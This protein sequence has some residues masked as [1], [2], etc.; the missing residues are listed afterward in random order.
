MQ[1]GDI[2]L[3]SGN[4]TLSRRIAKT[5][6][7]FAKSQNRPELISTGATEI[8]HVAGVIFGNV[9]FEAT[10]LNEWC[11]KKGVQVNYFDEWRK[12]YNGKIYLRE[13]TGKIN[14]Y[15]VTKCACMYIGTPYE[16]GIPGA[17]ELAL[18]G[19]EWQW[20]RK[21]F[22]MPNGLTETTSLHCS[23]V[24]AKVLIMSGYLAYV[25]A[26]KMPPMEWWGNGKFDAALSR[27]GYR[28]PVRIK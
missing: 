5:Q 7:F 22:N 12:N 27:T 13:N 11:G 10:T 17:L 4:G 8:T 16:S 2:L 15:V 1:T 19:I 23:E 25:Q 21:T 24:I 26:N 28:N 6:Q 18:T 20:F 9:V 3:C 14:P